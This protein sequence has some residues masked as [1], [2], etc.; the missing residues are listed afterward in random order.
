LSEEPFHEPTA[1]PD[2]RHVLV[3]RL[4][5]FDKTTLV[6]LEIIDARGQLVSSV[7]SP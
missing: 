2:G 3:A 6:R 1:D 5:D 7:R 4:D